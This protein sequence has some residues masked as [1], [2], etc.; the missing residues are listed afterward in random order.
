MKNYIG[1]KFGT[2]KVWSFDK[3]FYNN[4]KEKIDVFNNF[5]D[6]LYKN[7]KDVFS[8]SE[9]IKREIDTKKKICDILDVFFDLGCEIYNCFEN[10]KYK[11][12]NSYRKYVLNYG[13]EN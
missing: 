4:N 13:K 7:C 12:K 5:Y 6:K 11:N 3:D 9:K 10:K 2:I 8:A 1:L